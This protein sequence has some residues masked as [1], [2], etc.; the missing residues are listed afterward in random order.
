MPLFE[1]FLALKF[2]VPIISI[3]TA[4]VKNKDKPITILMSQYIAHFK[5]NK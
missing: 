4:T 5:G 2:K 1:Y 3:G